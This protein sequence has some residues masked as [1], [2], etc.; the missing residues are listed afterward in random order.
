MPHIEQYAIKHAH[1]CS[2]LCAVHALRGRVCAVGWSV[3]DF[4]SCLVRKSVSDLL[5]AVDLLS[6][7]ARLLDESLRGSVVL[8]Q[9]LQQRPRVAQHLLHRAHLHRLQL[10]T[11]PQTLAHS[12]TPLP[13]PWP[14]L[15]HNS[16]IR[17]YLLPYIDHKNLVRQ[18][19]KES[20]RLRLWI[21][22]L[23][24]YQKESCQLSK[25]TSCTS[26]RQIRQLFW[27]TGTLRD[28]FS[29]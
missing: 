3:I 9:P 24:A 1:N 18:S 19:I 14:S 23:V 2:V 16:P 26:Q 6:E 17:T 27:T 21:Y 15:M 13:W 8:L 7:D 12:T 20:C 22:W 29:K 11:P 10:T 5:H 4:I 25:R 28:V